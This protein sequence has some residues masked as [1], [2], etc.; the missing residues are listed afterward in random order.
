MGLDERHD[1]GWCLAAA[2]SPAPAGQTFRRRSP[3]NPL[4]I[5]SRPAAGTAATG[6]SRSRR[7][8]G[9]AQPDRRSMAAARRPRPPS[10]APCWD[11]PGRAGTASADRQDARG[12]AGYPSLGCRLPDLASPRLAR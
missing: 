5:R 2:A 9:Q 10:P 7:D 8:I 6:A 12:G 11:E 1:F 4:V 3:G